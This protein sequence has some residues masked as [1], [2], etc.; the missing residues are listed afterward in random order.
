MQTTLIFDG[1]GQTAIF[2]SAEDQ[3]LHDMDKETENYSWR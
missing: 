3:L 2:Y 1:Q